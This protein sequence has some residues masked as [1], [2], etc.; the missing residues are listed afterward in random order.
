MAPIITIPGAR[1]PSI[2]ATPRSVAPS[3]IPRTPGLS[4]PLF[5]A[6]ET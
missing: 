2:K 6:P 1:P 3:Q 4:P 5:A